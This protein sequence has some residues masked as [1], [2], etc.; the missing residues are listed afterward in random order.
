MAENVQVRRIAD[1]ASARVSGLFGFW[2]V[3]PPFI[4]GEVVPFIAVFFT[5]PWMS[6]LEFLPPPLES[7]ASATASGFD[8]AAIGSVYLATAAGAIITAAIVLRSRVKGA[9]LWRYASVGVLIVAIVVAIDAITP[10]TSLIKQLGQ[11]M[12]EATV[13]H[14][15]DNRGGWFPP[16]GMAVFRAIVLASGILGGIVTTLLALAVTSLAPPPQPTTPDANETAILAAAEELARRVRDLKHLLF[17]AGAILFAGTAFLKAWSSWPLAFWPTPAPG[18]S[19]PDP[20]ADFKIVEAALV[21]HQAIYFVLLIVAIFAPMAYWL[22]VAGREIARED[23]AVKRDPAKMK[24]WLA[25]HRITLSIA[26]QAQQI[27]AILLPLFAA[28]LADFFRS[29]LGY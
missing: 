12:F 27:V 21:N 14:Y 17:A 2:P 5:N 20:V 1:G 4:V 3:V 23:P 7:A 25:Q 28:P 16:D 15:L 13:G 22:S 24:T 29:L 9:A 8:V 11:P 10:S 26:E 6:G 19:V 18:S